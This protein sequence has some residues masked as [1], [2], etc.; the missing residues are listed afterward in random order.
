MIR[1]D[2][3]QN[4]L[5]RLAGVRKC[6]DGHEARCPGH[7]DQHASLSVALGDDGRVLLHCHAGCAPVAVCK[8]MGLRLGDLFPPNNNGD[9]HA[10]IEATYDYRDTAGELVFQVVRYERKQFKQRRPDGNGGWSWKLGRTPRVLYRLPELLAAGPDERVFVVEGEKDA[11]RLASAGLI[12]TCNPGG[13]GK[14][15]KM[16]DDSALHGRRV[17]IIPDKDTAGRDHAADVAMRLQNRAAEIRIVELPGA[18]KD[19][20]DWFDA[21]GTVDEL[22]RLV[23]AARDA[24]PPPAAPARAA[25]GQARPNVFIDTEEH[26]VVRETIAALRADPDLYQRGGILVRVIRDR[27]PTDG[28]LRCDGSATIQAMPAPNLRERMTRVA[29]FTKLNRKGEEVAAHPAA[30]LVSAVEARAEWDG[31]RHLMG[32]SDAPILRPDGSVWQAPGYDERTGV[33]YEPAPGASFPPIDSEVNIDDADAALTTLLEVVCDFPFESEEHKSAWLAA[34]LTP[35]ARFAFTGPSP[36]F[37]IDANTRGA[38]KGLLAQTIGRIVLG[39]EMP[40]SSYS[41]DADEMRKKITSI[42]IAGDRMILLDNLEGSFGND[43]LDRALTS[44][45]WKDR[46]LGKSEEIELPLIP[47]WYATGNNVQVAADTMRRIIHVRLDCL[48]ERP[49]ERSGFTHDNLLAWVEARRG[50]LLSAALTILSAYLRSG[51][52]PH[53]LKPFGSFEGWSNVV[54]EA[55]VWVG[56]P[57]PCL[58]RTKLAESADTTADALGQLVSAWRQYDWSGNGVVVSEM[59]NTLYPPQREQAQRDEASV[60]MRAAIENVVGCPPGKPPTSRQVGNKLRHFRR[61]V[62]GGVYLDFNP[63]EY[64]RS[65]VV[66]R[67][68]NVEANA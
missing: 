54:R 25:G 55:V 20:S 68:K 40:V 32:V 47:A 66:W 5:S 52:P 43:A 50:A 9:G 36:L 64:H 33:L 34:L 37:L 44:T 3:L 58:T 19:A 46:I 15:K 42:A 13:A 60:A 10:R 59:L 2:P 18:G 35:L 23:E 8:A 28:I 4:V 61:R 14:W 53:N 39:R 31:V 22:L 1:D 26:R 12:A 11:D 16:S 27:Q 49:E 7:D 6:G 17:V 30:W 38:G 21:G 48:N 62:V 45:R 57:D 63:N 24:P 41:H 56:L 29:T 51:R 67:L 65:G